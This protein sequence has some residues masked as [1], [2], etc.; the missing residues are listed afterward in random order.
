MK[1]EQKRTTKLS[2]EKK[3]SNATLGNVS[4]SA[5][6]DAIS[7]ILDVGARMLTTGISCEISEWDLPKTTPMKA[8]RKIV[9]EAE[10][11]NKVNR[12]RAIE[13]KSAYD[14]LS[15]HFC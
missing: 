10:R 5:V 13:L 14:V 15:K 12:L 8:K 6:R 1:Q 4:E 9:K 3:S 2:T 7:K 11:W